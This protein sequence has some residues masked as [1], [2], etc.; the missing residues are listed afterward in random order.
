[1]SRRVR[2]EG[3]GRLS[4]AIPWAA[5]PIA[6]PQNV[7]FP[8][9]WAFPMTLHRRET[10][11]PGDPAAFDQESRQGGQP[12]VLAVWAHGKGNEELEPKMEAKIHT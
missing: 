5:D 10:F 1:M 2:C 9:P 12:F 7:S 8:G 6:K 3:A 4:G 11:R